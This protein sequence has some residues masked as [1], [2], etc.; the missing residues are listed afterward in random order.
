MMPFDGYVPR[1]H[2]HQEVVIIVVLDMRLKYV[3]LYR[4][5]FPVSLNRYIYSDVMPLKDPWMEEMQGISVLPSFC[6]RVKSCTF[7]SQVAAEMPLQQAF[8]KMSQW[9]CCF[10]VH[11]STWHHAPH[12]EA[13]VRFANNANQRSPTWL[14]RR[15]WS[16]SSLVSWLHCFQE[17]FKPASWAMEMQWAMDASKC[18]PTGRKDTSWSHY[19]QD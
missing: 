11:L 12:K 14:F 2:Q 16:L 8:L 9:G 7:S 13:K 15:Q 3:D 4:T 10:A 18:N 1:S 5:S 6:L 17:L 19:V